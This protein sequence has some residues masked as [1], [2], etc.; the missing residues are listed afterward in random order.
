MVSLLASTFGRSDWLYTFTNESCSVGAGAGGTSF[1]P[2]GGSG[3]GVSANSA[4]AAAAGRLPGYW[5]D[6]SDGGIFPFGGAGGYGSTGNIQ[7]NKPMVGMASAPDAGGYWLVAA[8][9]GIFPFGDAGGYGSTGNIR[10]NKPVVGMAGRSRP[11]ER[12]A[13]PHGLCAGLRRLPR[14]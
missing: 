12:G 11:A 7:L 8:D 4:A 14:A 1:L 10:L 2:G 3:G 5:M 6:A 9:G 13:G